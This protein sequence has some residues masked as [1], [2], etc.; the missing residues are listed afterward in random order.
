MK[1]CNKCHV[2]KASECFKV[3]QNQ[4]KPCLSAKALKYYHRRMQTTNG[5]LHRLYNDCKHRHKKKCGE[6]ITF[7]RFSAIYQA[8]GGVC[9]ETGVPFDWGSKDLMPSPDRIDNA[10]GYTDG[11]V[12]FVTWRANLMRGGLSIED[13][14]A[15]CM[16]V[17][18]QT[19]YCRALLMLPN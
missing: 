2:A 9:I 12:R 13:F 1:T 16:Q 4:C 3:K 11:N 5:R 10:V 7:E 14:Q 15:T 18:Q 8:Q 19:H 17:V 6:M